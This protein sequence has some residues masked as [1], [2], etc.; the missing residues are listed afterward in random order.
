MEELK[1]SGFDGVPKDQYNATIAVM[2]KFS[3]EQ[4]TSIMY[5]FEEGTK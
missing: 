5:R 2:K 3:E 1:D 4:P